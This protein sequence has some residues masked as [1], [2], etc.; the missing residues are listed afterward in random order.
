MKYR[1]TIA[2]L[3]AFCILTVS[4]K[5]VAVIDFT[6][7]AEDAMTVMTV[8]GREVEYQEFRYYYLNNKRDSLGIESTPTDE[9]SLMLL[10][11]TEENIKNRHGLCLFAEKYGVSVTNSDVSEANEYVDNFKEENF[12]SDEEYLLA[13]EARYLTDYLFRSLQSESNLAYSVLEKM[14]ETGDIITAEEDIDEAFES[15]EIICIKEIYVAYNSEQT[16]N[17][18]N[19]RAEE[20][21]SKLMNGEE[22]EALMDEYSDYN[23]N[24]MPPEHGYYTMKYDALDVIWDTAISL[25]EGEYSYV[26][27]S[28]YGYH[29]V[30]RCPKDYEYMDTVR[31]SI[32]ERY[33]YAKFN[34]AIYT[35]IDTLEP[36]Y[37]DFGK[38]IALSEME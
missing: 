8:E 7:T 2:V 28:D 37:T 1:L 30:K 38:S 20:A 10:K 26:I 36:Q 25:A 12:E 6:P 11:L 15:D 19:L 32:Y 5:D 14:K 17:A 34:E 29:I 23:T 31:D 18:A 21:L 4:C 13:L 16:K 33:T 35:F 3:L 22:F 9:E 24:Q 27:E